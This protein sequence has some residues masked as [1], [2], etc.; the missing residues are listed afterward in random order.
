[1]TWDAIIRFKLSLNGVLVRLLSI[2]RKKT[3]GYYILVK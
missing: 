3:Y 1:M 2:D